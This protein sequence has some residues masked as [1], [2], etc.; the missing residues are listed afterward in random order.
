LYPPSAL[1]LAKVV[2]HA[3]IEPPLPA[4]I[5]IPPRPAAARAQL[6]DLTKFYNAGLKETWLPDA[7]PGSDLAELP[8]GVQNFDGIE[9]DVRGT[10]QLRSARQF[11]AHFPEQ[12]EDIPLGQ[13]CRR[14]HFFHSAHGGIF[15]DSPNFGKPLARYVVHYVDGASE[16]IPVVYGRDVRSWWRDVNNPTF[17]PP[18]AWTGHNMS[19]REHHAMILLY[20]TAWENPHPGVEIRSLDLISTLTECAAFVIA[21]TAE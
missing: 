21:I 10:I 13:K 18:P 16:E 19:S 11:D 12:V 8:S 2:F 5:N 14:L 4:S 20:H 7:T 15:A 3:D 1:S 17:I 9:F 6:L